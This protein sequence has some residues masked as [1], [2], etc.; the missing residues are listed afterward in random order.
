M[1]APA[2]IRL[3][4]FAALIFGR[5]AYRLAALVSTVALLPLWGADRYG[6]YAGAVAIFSWII[7]LLVAGP[8][9]TVLKLLPRAPRTGPLIIH[10]AG[11]L[12]WVLPVPALAAFA[13]AAALAPHGP[14]AVYLG[15]AAMSTTTGVLLLLVGLHR[16]VG[17]PWY[18]ARAFLLL[19]VAQVGLLGLAALGLGPLGYV[20][21][22]V[23]VQTALCVVLLTRLGRP[24]L[25]IRA[26]PA[27]VRR[28]WCTVVLMGSPDVCLYLSTGVLVALLSAS[29]FHDQVGPFVA[30]DIVW[31]AGVNFLIYALRVYTPWVSVRL[32]GARGAAARHAARRIAA[33]VIAGDLAYVAAGV[34]L[35]AATDVFDATGNPVIVWGV[36]FAAQT[37]MLVAL[38]LAGYLVENSDAP[39]TRITALATAMGLLAATAAGLVA[40]PLAGGVGVLIAFATAGIV[41][42]ATLRIKL[43]RPAPVKEDV[44]VAA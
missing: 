5:G 21:G 35:L 31:S 10:A 32:I 15:V 40:V 34:T 29:S 30:V 1:T 23:A 44:H 4:T 17:R 11:A 22:M 43:T 28:I 25:A 42:A 19:T 37:P 24:S 39:S 27:F 18:D 33:W 14:V 36:L 2:R 8:E 9:K 41:Q 26:R 38:I 6:T 16:A 3:P 20:A 13:T 12:L 7:A